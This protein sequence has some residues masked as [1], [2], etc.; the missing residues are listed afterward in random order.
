MLKTGLPDAIYM[1]SA[2]PGRCSRAA[3]LVSLH[4]S[5]CKCLPV[6]V[7]ADGIQSAGIASVKES[8][9]KVNPTVYLIVRRAPVWSTAH[10]CIIAFR[11][12]PQ[13]GDIAVHIY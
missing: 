12:L 11:S 8:A 5:P 10:S 1:Y 9:G 4:S 6:Y 13:Q 3:A 2:A 7:I